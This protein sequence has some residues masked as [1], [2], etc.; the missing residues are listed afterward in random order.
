[1]WFDIWPDVSTKFIDFLFLLLCKGRVALQYNCRH[2]H[3]QSWS[4]IKIQT[5]LN[6]T[7]LRDK[8]LIHIIRTLTH[9][10]GFQQVSQKDHLVFLVSLSVQGFTVPL[11]GAVK[12]MLLRC[13]E[14]LRLLRT[15]CSH[16]EKTIRI[17]CCF[18]EPG[19]PG[20]SRR[21]LWSL[22]QYITFCHQ[23]FGRVEGGFLSL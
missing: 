17:T 20:E 9:L 4:L 1:M 21:N 18:H 2:I 5:F 14:I 22:T 16:T 12:V 23:G 3:T 6:A 15:H 13:P 7:L 19:W 10:I 11:W 8:T